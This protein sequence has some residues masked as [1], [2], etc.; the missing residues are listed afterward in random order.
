MRPGMVSKIPTSPMTYRAIIHTETG[1]II[2]VTTDESPVVD[3]DKYSVVILADNIDFSVGA[4]WKK[5]VDGEVVDATSDDIDAADVDPE[6]RKVLRTA[7]K[8]AVLSAIDTIA[9]D[10]AVPASL[11]AFFAAFRDMIG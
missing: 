3:N 6:R 4:R 5:V 11:K 8:D 9:S 7:T 1:V 10:D 2:S